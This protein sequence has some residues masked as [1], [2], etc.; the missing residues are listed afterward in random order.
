[1]AAAGRRPKD[2]DSS[3]FARVRALCVHV[4]TA[5]GAAL[6]LL[7]LIA[8]GR[9]DWTRMFFWLGLALIVDAVDGTLARRFNSAEVLPR[10]SGDVLDLVVDFSTYVLVPAYAIAVGGL[11]PPSTA[12]PL[13]IAI[14]VTS[15][16]YSAD[17]RMKTADNYFRG[18]PV[19]WNLVAFYL[20]LLRPQPWVGAAAVAALIVLTFVPL[21]FV[22]PFRVKTMRVVNIGLL[23]LWSICAVLALAYDLAPG[24]WITGT[25]GVIALYFLAA[26]FARR[27]D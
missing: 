17:I 15:A 9:G 19:V 12:I 2:L 14:V 25:L 13:S 23:A 4:L 27:A 7:A 26:G 18:F 8:A 5:A 16:L 11:L 21:P 24:P 10:W 6:A 1:M 22:H 3:S 20:F